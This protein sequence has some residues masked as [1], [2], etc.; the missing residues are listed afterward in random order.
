MLRATVKVDLSG[1]V[2][3]LHI[4]GEYVSQV[5]DVPVYSLLGQES[6]KFDT[7]VVQ[8]RIVEEDQL[9]HVSQVIPVLLSV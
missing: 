1:N 3:D 7:S 4:S 5:V 2:L 8:R 6:W 9:S